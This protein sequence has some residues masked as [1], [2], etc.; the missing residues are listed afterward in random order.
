[1]GAPLSF[2]KKRQNVSE[3]TWQQV[4]YH[5]MKVL[6][7]D[8]VGIETPETNVLLVKIFYTCAKQR[9]VLEIIID[10]YKIKT[11]QLRWINA[12]T[13]EKKIF[14]QGEIRDFR[15]SLIDIMPWVEAILK[16]KAENTDQ[17]IDI[18]RIIQQ[19]KSA[20]E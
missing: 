15:L 10:S 11:C 19:I 2:F 6:D 1:M 18:E 3:A 12:P 5:F 14:H 16:K 20:I 4:M 7:R 9:F 13:E 8:R 17:D